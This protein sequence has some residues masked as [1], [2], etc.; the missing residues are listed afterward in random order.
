LNRLPQVKAFLNND[1]KNYPDLHVVYANGDPRIRFI[2]SEDGS[3]LHLDPHSYRVAEARGVD[4]DK[5][6]SISH[7][8][9]KQ[10]AAMVSD[11]GVK[12][13]EELDAAIALAKEKQK[14]NMQQEKEL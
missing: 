3:P 10:I 6:E 13:Y 9:R 14:Q 11:R 5:F 1:A 2:E 12:T 7:L 8:S 4:K